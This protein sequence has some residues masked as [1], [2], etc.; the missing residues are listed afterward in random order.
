MLASTNYANLLFI[1]VKI[2]SNKIKPIWREFTWW[3]LVPKKSNKYGGESV[4]N[5]LWHIL[6]E[7][8][9][10]ENRVQTNKPNM[11]GSLFQKNQ[12]NTAGNQFQTCSDIFCRKFISMK[13]GT[14]KI[15]PIRR[16]KIHLWC[17]NHWYQYNSLTCQCLEQSNHGGRWR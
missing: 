1:C 14:K 13:I 17:L 11:A 6:R 7:I 16:E 2:G 3:K 5:M 12:T 8:H 15:N 9:L 10:N 4:P